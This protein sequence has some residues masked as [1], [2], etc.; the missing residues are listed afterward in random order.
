MHG[1]Q[2]SSLP[3]SGPPVGSE[4]TY[5]SRLLRIDLLVTVSFSIP[6][7]KHLNVHITII[8]SSLSPQTSALP[9]HV[10][11]TGISLFR[12]RVTSVPS[13]ILNSSPLPAISH[14]HSPPGSSI[15]H[16]LVPTPSQTLSHSILPLRSHRP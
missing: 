6:H 12:K 1:H 16:D 15:L 11:T 13:T 9:T 3:F 4:L 7:P 14:P 2:R 10:Y 8:S 5:H